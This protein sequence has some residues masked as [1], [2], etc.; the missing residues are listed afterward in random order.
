MKPKASYFLSAS[1][2]GKGRGWS[3]SQSGSS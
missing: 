2:C 3:A 1:P